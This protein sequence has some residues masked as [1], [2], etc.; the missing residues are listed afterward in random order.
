MPWY[1]KAEFGDRVNMDISPT[2]GIPLI[3][4]TCSCAT[5]ALV[6]TMTLLKRMSCYF[7]L[8]YFVIF[9]VP[10]SFCKLED[11]EG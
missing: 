8:I 11:R 6:M 10:G 4:S 9:S 2:M 5:L 3:L 7:C 1:V